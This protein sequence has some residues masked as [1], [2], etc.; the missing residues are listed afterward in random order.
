M[1]VGSASPTVGSSDEHCQFD[2]YVTD[3]RSCR[4]CWILSVGLGIE[5][6]L[7]GRWCGLGATLQSAFVSSVIRVSPACELIRL[8]YPIREG[9]S[10]TC[11]PSQR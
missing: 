2:S 6:E 1:Q 5:L 7:R 10:S 4:D 9:E 11:L 3:E 8:Q